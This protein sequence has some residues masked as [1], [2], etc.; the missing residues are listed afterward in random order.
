MGGTPEQVR[1]ARWRTKVS[2]LQEASL[3]PWSAPGV[4]KR[5]N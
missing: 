1:N 3:Q 5:P 4:S 2:A